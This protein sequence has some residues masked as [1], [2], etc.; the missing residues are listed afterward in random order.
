VSASRRRLSVLGILL[1]LASVVAG[2]AAPAIPARA[3][4]GINVTSDEAKNNF[5]ANVTFN[6]AFTADAA[7]KE[8]RIFYELA[9]D[10][11]G[12]TA[13]AQCNGTTSVTCSYA[14]TN[15]R[16]IEL[17]PG[18]NITYHWEIT[19]DDGSQFKTDDKLFVYDDTRF[20]FKTLQDGNVTLYYHAGSQS[21]AQQVL[22]AA[23][24]S[25]QKVSAL[26][27]TQ[28]TFPVKVFLY[29]TAEEM[30][31]AIVSGSIG[32]GVVVLG[33]VV[34]SDTAMVSADADPLNV[35]R[36]VVAHIVTREATKGPYG[37]DSWLNEGIS[38]WAQDEVLQGHAQALR[39]AIQS[40]SVLS[41]RE[42]SSPSAGDAAQTVNLFYG[43]SGSIV[44]FLVDKYGADKFAELL[45][46]FKDGSTPD[47]AYQKV[48]GF[49]TLGLEN[50][51]R[52]SVGLSARPTPAAA[53]AT[54][55]PPTPVPPTPVPVATS[56]AASH[57]PSSGGRNVAELA[58]IA[59]LGVVVVGSGAGAYITLR[60]R[61]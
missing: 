46:T 9:P 54:P 27:Q 14:L 5:P 39:D 41:L 15:G 17:I 23:V 7:P 29:Q 19:R 51:W 13:V 42:L 3:Q 25:L 53:S 34:Y 32:R 59:V 11:T 40:D 1:A 8:V 47:N 6:L 52:A 61:L 2:I 33:E 56:T 24:G 4:S 31:P 37:I 50:A 21:A 26:E 38:V 16:G 45:S 20:S 22:D 55:V 18:A 43:E 60:R 30:Q 44:K 10:G 48:Y 12:A 49:D 35:T 58:A 57:G 36:H 28:V